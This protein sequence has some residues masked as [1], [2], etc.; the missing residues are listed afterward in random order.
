MLE[1]VLAVGVRGLEDPPV[2]ELGVGGEAALR[3]A[4]R[5]RRPTEPSLLQPRH[6]VHGVAF[7]HVL[8]PAPP[9]PIP[10]VEPVSGDSRYSD[11]RHSQPSQAWQVGHQKRLRAACVEVRTS[12]P[13]TRQGMPARR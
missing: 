4:H 6:A 2:D 9:G 7:G 1:Q 11:Y 8:D 12:V 10:R 5:D 13:Q 3:A